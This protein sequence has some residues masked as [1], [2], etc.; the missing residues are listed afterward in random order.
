M[1]LTGPNPDHQHMLLLLILNIQMDHFDKEFVQRAV[2]VRTMCQSPSF[3]NFISRLKLQYELKGNIQVRN[4][5]LPIGIIEEYT[6]K[7]PFIGTRKTCCVENRFTHRI[8]MAIDCILQIADLT[9]KPS[10]GFHWKK[11]TVM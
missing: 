1:K 5:D 10:T 11:H 7:K 9:R 6:G 3:F 2:S 8:F 4:Q